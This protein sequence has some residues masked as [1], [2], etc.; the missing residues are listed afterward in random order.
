MRY[1][2][3]LI[4]LIS[5]HAK[6]DQCSSLVDSGDGV[7]AKYYQEEC[8][9]IKAMDSG[10]YQAAGIHYSNALSTQIFESPNYDLRLDL[11]RAQCLDGRIDEGRN[12]LERF[13]LMAR[14]ELGE[15]KCPDGWDAKAFPKHFHLVCD[16]YGSALNEKGRKKVKARLK[17]AES[18]E[19]VC[20]NA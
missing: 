7:P 13:K 6:G 2:S 8:R 20:E 14:G 9:A 1:I 17:E 18:V 19:S 10:N 5:F 12:N 16:G 15:V 4:L 11:A 3:V